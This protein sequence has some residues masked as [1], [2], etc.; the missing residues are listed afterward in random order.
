MHNQETDLTHFV[1]GLS[2][3]DGDE[4]WLKGKKVVR[5]QGTDDLETSFVDVYPGGLK[6][7]TGLP[8]VGPRLNM[9]KESV[10]LTLGPTGLGPALRLNAEGLKLSVG[11]TSISL[12][13]EAG[14]EMRFGEFS[15]RLSEAGLNVVVGDHMLNLTEAGCSVMVGTSVLELSPVGLTVNGATIRLAADADATLEGPSVRLVAPGA[16][17]IDAAIM[18]KI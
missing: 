11:A 17:S 6:Q 16:L 7:G 1:K 9:N 12:T 13:P 5:L 8:E 18:E 4:V 2:T 15:L 10:S 14:I 3:H